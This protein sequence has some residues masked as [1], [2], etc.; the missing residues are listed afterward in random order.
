MNYVVLEA[1]DFLFHIYPFL[2]IEDIVIKVPSTNKSDSFGLQL[3]GTDKLYQRIYWK[4]ILPKY[5]VDTSI[6][7]GK[8]RSL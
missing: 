7:K 6:T 3:S 8:K 4:D 1:N 5:C 2:E